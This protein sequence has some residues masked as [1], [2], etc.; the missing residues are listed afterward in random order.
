MDME[1]NQPMCLIC[2]QDIHAVLREMSASLAEPRVET[3]HLQREDE[4]QT[5]KLS[6][7]ESQ[8][9]EVDKLKQQ[10]Q[11]QTAKLELQKT[12]LEKQKAEGDNWRGLG[13][14]RMESWESVDGNQGLSKAELPKKKREEMRKELRNG[15]R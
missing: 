2:P 11:A 9:M 7:L 6:N 14:R 13:R 1:E 10:L 15:R 4:A 12:E 5:A 3:R 8:M